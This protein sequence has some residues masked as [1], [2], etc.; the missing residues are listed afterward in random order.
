MCVICQ[1]INLLDGNWRPV[2]MSTLHSGQNEREV[3]RILHSHPREERTV[4]RNN[5]LL[6]CLSPLRAFGDCRFKL[7][8]DELNDLEGKLFEIHQ[9]GNR[10]LAIL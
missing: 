3:T 9:G 4:L 7:T 5:R 6:G 1:L 8:F 10:D 2:K